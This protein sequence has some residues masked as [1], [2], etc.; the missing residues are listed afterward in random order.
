[1]EYGS[2]FTISDNKDRL[3]IIHHKFCK[4]AVSVSTNVP[5]L[6]IYGELGHTYSSVNKEESFKQGNI[7]ID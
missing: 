5:S 3:E 4:F 7:D 6:V 1:M 2:D